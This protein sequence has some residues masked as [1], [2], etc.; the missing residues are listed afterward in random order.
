[1]KAVRRL[2]K[3]SS[4]VHPLSRDGLPEAFFSKY[5]KNMLEGPLCLNPKPK[6]RS[7]SGFTFSSCFSGCTVYLSGRGMRYRQ[8]PGRCRKL[9]TGELFETAADLQRVARLRLH[10]IVLL[11][12]PEY[13][14]L[15][16]NCG[17]GSV[18]AKVSRPAS[19]SYP[20]F[21]DYK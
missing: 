16:R 1:M 18:A 4:H 13:A 9:S 8:R 11:K 17:D 3:T 19:S 12:R 21:L 6:F 10:N 20:V 15:Y 2:P 5:M 7:E 14:Y